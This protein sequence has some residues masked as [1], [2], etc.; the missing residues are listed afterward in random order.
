MFHS[1]NILFR[2]W[3]PSRSGLIL[4]LF[5]SHSLAYS[6]VEKGLLGS[7]LSASAKV[8]SKAGFRRES[9]TGLFESRRAGFMVTYPNLDFHVPSSSCHVNLIGMS[10]KSH[11]RGFNFS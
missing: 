10:S 7:D 4:E 1:I 9:V 5:D 8:D 2:A 11:H 3:C 6:I